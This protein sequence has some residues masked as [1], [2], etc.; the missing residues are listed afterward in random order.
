MFSVLCFVPADV[1]GV[2]K[3]LKYDF[4]VQNKFEHLGQTIILKTLQI[5]FSQ[6]IKAELP[7]PILQGCIAFSAK[8]LS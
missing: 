4:Y 7:H 1:L 8:E 2:Q 5:L 3:H 6:L